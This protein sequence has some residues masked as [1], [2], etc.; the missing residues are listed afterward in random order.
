MRQRFQRMIRAD[1]VGEIERTTGHMVAFVS[2]NHVET[3]LAAELF[4]LDAPVD[5]EYAGTDGGLASWDQP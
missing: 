5:G 1:L 3:D 4:L 2:D